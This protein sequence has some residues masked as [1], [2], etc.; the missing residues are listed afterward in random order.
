[1]DP[2]P[3]ENTT[4]RTQEQEHK[5]KRGGCA[6]VAGRMSSRR[7]SHRIRG[8]GAAASRLL[9]SAISGTPDLAHR[10]AAASS[11][12]GSDGGEGIAAAVTP[13]CHRLLL[14][15]GSGRRS[16]AS[17]H[18][19]VE[20]AA[21]PPLLPVVG[22]ATHHRQAPTGSLVEGGRAEKERMREGALAEEID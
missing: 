14:L 8:G 18:G 19:S 3:R 2:N 5:K 21:V 17:S 16:R 7:S 15:V 9:P 6:T 22:G 10:V 11:P 20:G 4:I 12:A 13:G 1:M